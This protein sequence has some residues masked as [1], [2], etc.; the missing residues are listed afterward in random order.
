VVLTNGLW[1]RRYAGDPA[2]VGHTVALNEQSCLITGILP[3][4]FRFD[5]NSEIFIPIRVPAVPERGHYYYMLARLKPGVTLD[6]AR[7]EMPTLFSRFKAAHGDLVDDGETGI[8]VKPYLDSFIGDVRPS[9][10][11]LLGAVD[12]V[13]LLACANVANLL[14][15]RATG[16]TKEMAVRAA[17]GAGRRRL[18]RQLITEGLLLACAGGGFGFLLA[19]WGI[20]MLRGVA[21]GSLPRSADISIDWPV[22]GF[23]F[24][25]SAFTVLAFG[26]APALQASRVDVDTSLKAASGRGSA[27]AGRARTRAL[28][29]S[30]EVALS[31]VLLTGAVLLMRSFIALRDVALGFDPTNVLTFQISP[32]PR[33]STTPRLWEFEHH[34]LEQLSALPAV[35]TAASAICMPLEIGPEMPSA[36]LG[37]PQPTLFSPVYRP[38]SPNYFRALK[39][40]I[41]QG[42]PFADTDASDATPVIIINDSVARQLFMGRDPLG[43]HIQLGVGLGAEY[44]DP[45]RLVVGVAGDVRET[46]LDQPAHITVFIPRAQVPSSLTATINR[47]VGTS[48]AVRTKIPPAELASAV[49][50]T[51]LT[52]DRQEP[53]SNVSSMEEKMSAAVERQRFTL[54]LMILFAAL[55]ILLAAVGIY[56]VISYSVAQRTHEI[57]IRMA[58][59]ERRGH[60][61]GMVIGS[62][63]K[64]ACIGVGIGIVVSLMLTRLLSSL[65]FSTRPTDL[66]T[67]AVVPLLLLAVAL[68]ACYI[69]ARRAARV[70]PMAA[71]RYE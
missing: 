38:V 48:W 13:L 46:S 67:F 3:A 61:L 55:G 29:V 65:L 21:P 25:L 49:R 54:L 52:I 40:P 11:V 50:R 41:I 35:E 16:R 24:F 4:S 28:L 8:G 9:L 71:L 23:T 64:L 66:L 18:A 51:I 22:A 68:V 56:G 34:V 59:G 33:Y 62:G 31:A 30:T 17:L 43:E 1:R 2:I 27:D 37:R 10:W 42:R 39:I 7:A 26:L 44:A 70:D 57:G 47:L 19:H 15:L 45:P 32:S 6:Q 63:M 53:I 69:P 20:L 60:M 5:Q 58:L 14:S 12:L 36:V